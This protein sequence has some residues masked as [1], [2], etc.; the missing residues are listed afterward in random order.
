MA[1]LLLLACPSL[2]VPPSPPQHPPTSWPTSEWSTCEWF[3]SNFHTIAERQIFRENDTKYVPTPTEC[4]ALARKEGC[5]IANT[6]VNPM[7]SN[8]CWCQFLWGMAPVKEEGSEYNTCV[9]AT[10]STRQELESY[11]YSAQNGG[12]SAPIALIVGSAGLALGL[13]GGV[14]YFIRRRKARRAKEEAVR[15]RQ[16]E[17][18]WTEI[19]KLMVEAAGS[20]IGTRNATELAEESRFATEPREL[21][22]GRPAKS[23]LGIEYYMCV[24]RDVVLLGMVEGT[25]AIVREVDIGGSAVDREC[26]DYILHAEAGSSERAFQAGLRRDCDAFGSVLPS[27]T[28]E[29]GSTG[30]LRGMRLE[31]FVNHQSARLANL[32]E[33]HVVALR[34]YTTQA[35]RAI[36]TPLRERDRF[37]RGE[38]HPMPVTVALLRDAL[39]KLRAVEAERHSASPNTAL[40][41]VELYR[42]MKDV[43]APADFMA[44]GGT[45]LAP[46]S[47]TSDLSVAMR[48]SASSHAVLLRL[49]TESFYERG[50][51]ISFLSAFPGEAE[52]LFPPLTYLQPTGTSRRW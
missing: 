26:L 15:Q 3:P 46:M 21:V 18:G 11:L 24:A 23:A 9:L 8:G 22:F 32:T 16:Q 5:D 52:F 48:Y 34:F 12:A 49:I 42:G 44:Q 30:K 17:Q 2:T 51:D 36:N 6:D 43:T 14:M 33:A 27:R 7:T 35:Y 45:E 10:T 41:R 38:P 29:D 13:T 37:M 20:L 19:H 50:P 40:R 1:K 31:D 25:A 39:G 4:I 28:V 47:T